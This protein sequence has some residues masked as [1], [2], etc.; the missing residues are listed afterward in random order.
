MRRTGH[1]CPPPYPH[2]EPPPAGR[3]RQNRDRGYLRSTDPELARADRP[4]RRDGHRPAARLEVDDRPGPRPGCALGRTERAPG[5]A[6]GPRHR[7][8][9]GRPA[10]PRPGGVHC[11]RDRW[12]VRPG[13]A[14]RTGPHRR[15]AGRHRHAFPAA[16]RRAWPR[17]RSPSTATEQA[18]QPAAGATAAGAGRSRGRHGGRRRRRSAP[19]RPRLRA[20]PRRRGH[21]RRLDLEPARL[22]PAAGCAGCTSAASRSSTS[23]RRCRAHHIWR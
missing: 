2:P 11:G 3:T 9:V 4:R 14:A 18:R 22:R 7:A 15:R 23:A 5:A 1:T 13:I 17:V 20:G 10:R 8:D 19:D 16:G 21:D 12:T 6:A